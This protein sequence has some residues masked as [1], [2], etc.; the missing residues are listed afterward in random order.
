L[1]LQ[2][3]HKLFPKSL[4]HHHFNLFFSLKDHILTQSSLPSTTTN[5]HSEK[6]EFFS[7]KNG[8]FSS[9]NW[10]SFFSSKHTHAPKLSLSLSQLHAP[11]PQLSFISVAAVLGG[12]F[13]SLF[14][15][16]V[17]SSNN[18]YYVENIN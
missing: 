18:K 12:G 11:K 6:N 3:P 2:I 1:D 13:I 10:V 17:E 7:F 15:S 8:F 5:T 4:H 14:S 16:T 9:K